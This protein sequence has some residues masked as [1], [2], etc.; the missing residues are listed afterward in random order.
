MRT[1]SNELDAAK[2]GVFVFYH[3]TIPGG[4]EK[5]GEEMH[6]ACGREDCCVM[7]KAWIPGEAYLSYPCC[8]D[9]GGLVLSSRDSGD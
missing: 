7:Q 5:G 9:G 2:I 8:A 4:A 6:V 1:A 3:I